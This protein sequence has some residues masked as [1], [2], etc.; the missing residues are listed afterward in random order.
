MFTFCYTA[1]PGAGAIFVRYLYR[2]EILPTSQSLSPQL[3][4][5]VESSLYLMLIVT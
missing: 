1:N 3:K 2:V 4:L 5:M